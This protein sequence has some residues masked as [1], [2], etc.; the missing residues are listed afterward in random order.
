[1]RK[2]ILP[3]LAALSLAACATP[4]PPPAT[5]APPRQVVRA[6]PPPPLARSGPT[7]ADLAE[8]APRF[9]PSVFGSLERPLVPEL[10]NGDANLVV[11][12]DRVRSWLQTNDAAWRD[13]AN[14]PRAC[15][16]EAQSAWR[17]LLQEAQAGPASER[18]A[19]LNEV[20]NRRP[21][22]EDEQVY[23]AGDYWANPQE[24]LANSGDC[25]DF[26]VAKYVALRHLGYRDDELRVVVLTD[27]IRD[28]IHAVLAVSVPGDVV[29]LDSLSNEIFSHRDYAHYVPH[30][31]VNL[32]G[33]FEHYGRTAPL[34]TLPVPP[35]VGG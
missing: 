11:Q 19:R 5:P 27:R 29:I 35:A 20:F 1:M 8:A 14:N 18:L 13:C 12:W 10:A 4:A 22:L 28:R 34:A 30:L 24:F 15:R 26:A 16:T 2:S 33:R 32:S 9:R 7:L 6:A 23:G 21:Y 3:L 25:E 31:S 17:G